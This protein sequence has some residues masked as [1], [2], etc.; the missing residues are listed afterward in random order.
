MLIKLNEYVL[1]HDLQ[2]PAEKSRVELCD[3]ELPGLY[4]EVRATRQGQGTYYLRY[5]D[6]DGKT[7]HQKI[8]RTSEIDLAEARQRAKKLKAEIQLGSDP[9]GEARVQ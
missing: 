2:C 9:R 6:R 4:V 8:G 1:R 5:K 7:C 3:S